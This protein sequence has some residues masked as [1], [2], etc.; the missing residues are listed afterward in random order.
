VIEWE[1]VSPADGHELAPQSL[2][3][4][5][6]WL[7]KKSRRLRQYKETIKLCRLVPSNPIEEAA[8]WSK[9]KGHIVWIGLHE[10]GI[11][12][13]HLHPLAI[14]DASNAYQQPK[15]E[16]YGDARFV[17]ARTAQMAEAQIAFGEKHLFVGTGCVVSV[18]HGA[19]TSY[20]AVRDRCESCPTSLAKGE[21][22]IL[23]AIS[24]SSWTITAL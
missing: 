3:L 9:K 22:Y 23:Y 5:I 12:Q 10:R 18:R 2:R 8:D 14:E 7:A 19:S 21:D 15:V 13:F 20:K 4:W 11:A 16:Q 1:R 6:Y 24:T 17:M